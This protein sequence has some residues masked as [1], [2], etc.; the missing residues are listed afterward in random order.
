MSALVAVAFAAAP[1][2]GAQPAGGDARSSGHPSVLDPRA[3]TIPSPNAP[4]IASTYP[5]AYPG[6][7]GPSRVAAVG[8]MMSFPR[9]QDRPEQSADPL[10]GMPKGESRDRGARTIKGHT[11]PYPRLVDSPFAA[12]SFYVGTTVDFLFQQGVR[13]GQEADDSGEIVGATYDRQLGFIQL[14]Y[15]AEYAPHERVS[16]GLNADYLATVGAN[17]ESLFLY[18]GQ[19]GFDFRPFLRVVLVRSDAAGIQWSLGGF[20][21]YENGIRAVPQGL[22]VELSEQIDAIAEDPTGERTQCLAQGNL[23]CA[24]AEDTDFNSMQ[25]ARRRVGG[26]GNTAVAIALNE[27]L[28]LQV[29]GQ[30]E[31]AE[32]AIS[33]SLVGDVDALDLRAGAGIAPSLYLTDSLPVTLAA[34]YRFEWQQS[35]Y[36]ANPNLDIENG[37]RVAA[38]N[39]RVSAGIYYAGRRDLMLGWT[40]AGAR[41]EDAERGTTQVPSAGRTTSMSALAPNPHA[42]V[43][44]GQFDMRYFF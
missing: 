40:A 37:A 2:W 15:G 38:F 29:S 18:G 1:A 5:E 33:N 11:F 4:R 32:Q 19:T 12:S 27:Y 16:F 44:S 25:L 3:A 10:P 24:F 43:A 22:L 17:E 36:R 9:A 7:P 6:G 14:N 30:F 20:G 21:T 23:D 34:G 28:G 26:G 13:S 39:H 41:L 42:W 35:T 31:A 8:G